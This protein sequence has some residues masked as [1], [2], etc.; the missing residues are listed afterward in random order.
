MQSQSHNRPPSDCSSLASSAR[1]LGCQPESTGPQAMANHDVP[2]TPCRYRCRSICHSRRCRPTCRSLLAHGLGS[3]SPQD[4]TVLRPQALFATPQA[5]IYAGDPLAC[6]IFLPLSDNNGGTSTC[7][8]TGHLQ[9]DMYHPAARCDAGE[10]LRSPR[11][12]REPSH[13]RCGCAH[14]DGK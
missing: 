10:P 8:N 6:N 5:K 11:L 9:S 1:P 2:R 7:S 3:F 4:C 12:S 13:S 14:A